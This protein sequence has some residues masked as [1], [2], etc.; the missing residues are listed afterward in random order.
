MGKG[1]SMRLP[2]PDGPA[3]RARHRCGVAILICLTLVSLPAMAMPLYGHHGSTTVS[4]QVRNGTAGEGAP[5]GLEVI[6]HTFG[7]GGEV[8]VA[9]AVTGGDG[10]FQFQGLETDDR[11]SYAVTANYREVM[12]S[13]RLEPNALSEPVELL[14]YETTG[15]LADIH[16]GVDILLFSRPEQD[17]ESLDALEVVSVV[18]S[19]DRT[20]VPSLDEPG[21]MSFLRFSLP[22][23]ATSPDIASDLAGGDIIDVGTGFALTAPVPPGSHRVTYTYRL[24][25]EGSRLELAHSFPMGAEAF[26]LLLEDGVGNLLDPGFL[27]RVPGG[28]G[29]E[30]GPGVWG[31]SQILP[32]TRLNVEIDG[33]PQPS[34]LSRTGDA[35][36]DGPY[37]TVGIPAVV[38]L[39]LAG[40]LVYALFL[41]HPAGAPAVNT[42][43]GGRGSVP[44]V[45]ASD[46]S[47]SSQSERRALVEAIAGLDDLFQRREV[48]QEE[49]ERRR[50]DLKTR[51]L[52]LT[53]SSE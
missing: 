25:Y 24:P 50:Q 10:R 29:Q 7:E 34:F 26:R 48:A 2:L 9:S 17:E 35:L 4:G 21:S 31:A 18:N 41:R 22:A 16:I 30:A 42:G 49:Y 45:G 38:G 40:L 1:K 27:T 52:Q 19:G 12:Y 47:A 6:L 13:R 33:L 39:V 14:V 37:L 28:G 53:R 44:V 15:S 32:G 23:A 36:T 3:R 43:I 46:E 8:D 5:A 20:F 51:L 11:S